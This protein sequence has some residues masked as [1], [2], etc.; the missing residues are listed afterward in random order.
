MYTYVTIP[1]TRFTHDARS[2][3]DD[4]SE[5]ARERSNDD[6][7]SKW[8]P[9]ITCIIRR[10]ILTFSLQKTRLD[11]TNNDYSFCMQ[12]IRIFPLHVNSGVNDSQEVIDEDSD[13]PK[14]GTPGHPGI[15]EGTA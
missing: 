7:R 13:N 15:D 12:D 1:T 9:L 8:L 2:Y 11:V 10:S 3:V 4:E 6:L 14:A 5:H